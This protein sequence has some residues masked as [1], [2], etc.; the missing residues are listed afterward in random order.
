MSKCRRACSSRTGSLHHYRPAQDV[1]A[2]HELDLSALLRREFDVHRL[3]LDGPTGLWSNPHKRMPSAPRTNVD[4][5]FRAFSDRTRL[6][7]L[8]LVR[9]D[10]LCVCDLVEIL[11]MP[12]PTV[13]RHLSY[14]RRAGLVRARQQRSWNFYSLTPA[15]GAFH[16]KLLE[17]LVSCFQDVPELSSD[18]HR[19]KQLVA[20]GG[21]CPE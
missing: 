15:H 20:R 1:H 5:M 17:C 8:H 12:Q 7:I 18:S 13:S 10:E 6:R 9:E 14:L 19:A 3:C 2:A 21:C 16:R 11:K 4:L